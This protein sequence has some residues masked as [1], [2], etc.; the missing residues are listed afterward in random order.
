MVSTI[1]VCQGGLRHLMG[2]TY[3]QEEILTVSPE[4]RQSRT[5]EGLRSLFL[6]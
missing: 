5:F 2:L 4:V 6:A 3:Q 1:R